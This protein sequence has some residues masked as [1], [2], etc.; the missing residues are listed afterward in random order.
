MRALDRR[1]ETAERQRDMAQAEERRLRTLVQT[2]NETIEQLRANRMLTIVESPFLG[3]LEWAVRYARA[4]LADSLRRGESP[5][6][7]HLLYPQVLDDMDPESRRMGLRAGLALYPQARACAV[8]VDFGVTPGMV[9]GILAA[10]GA[11]TP[12]VYRSFGPIVRQMIAN[13]E[14]PPKGTISSEGGFGARL[15]PVVR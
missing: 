12:I 9:E 6:A 10:Q 7:S 1:L 5:F 3:G 14:E 13:G 2:S 8:Y 11:T 4:A 15:V